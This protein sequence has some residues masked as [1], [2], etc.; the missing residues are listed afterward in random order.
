MSLVMDYKPKFCHFLF[1]IFTV[2]FITAC[3][4]ELSSEPLAII[5]T[6][7]N[8][9]YYDSVFQYTFGVSGGEGPYR[10]RY[11]QNPEG[12]EDQDSSFEENPVEMSIEVVDGAKP[13]FIL[14]GTP[15]VPDGVSFEELDSGKFKY[16]LEVSD[17]N[18]TIKREFEFTLKKNKLNFLDDLT[19][20]EG[21]VENRVVGTLNTQIAVENS[22]VC[23]QVTENALT[24]RVNEFGETVYPF[25]FQVVADV[26]TASKTEIFYRF[27][28]S[29]QESQPERAN[30]NIS[31][32]RK[33]VDYVD[34]V[35][36]I[37]LEANKARC[38]AYIEL[39][40]D[41][42]IE[43][44][45]SVTIEFYDS[46][47]GAIDLSAASSTL[48]IR[49]NEIKPEYTTANMVRN[50]GDKIVVPI[51][52]NR[53]V[54]YPISVN[55]SVD[56]DTTANNEDFLLEP[57]SGVV[58]LAPGEIQSSYVITLLD[59]ASQDAS[60]ATK[61]KS[62][63]ITTDLDEILNVEPLT[64]EINEWAS[65]SDISKEIVGKDS[66]TEKII[67]FTM[68][69][70]G[71]ITTLA[72]DIK[73][74]D[75]VVRLKSYRRDATNFDFSMEGAIELSKVG[76]DLKPVSIQ[77]SLEGEGYRLSIVL[78]VNGLYGDVFRG[79][80]DFVVMNYFRNSG[81]SFNLMSVKQYG[82]EG[83][84]EVKGSAILGST[85]Y[86]YGN[87]NGSDFEGTPTN[88]TNSGGKDGFIY[89]INLQNNQFQWARFLGTNDEDSVVA[90][91]VANRD[92]VAAISTKTTDEDV[93]IRKL[94]ANNGQDRL[95][96]TPV[97]I[98]SNNLDD[99]A[100]AIEFD[101]SA[102]SFRVL[103]DS[104]ADLDTD[105]EQTPT[106]SRDVQLL[107][108]NLDNET[109]SVIAYATEFE[110][111]AKGLSTMPSNSNLIVS[112]ETFGEFPD[113]LKR[114]SGDVDLFT[115]II[116]LDRSAG[117]K[118]NKNIQFG[119][120]KNDSIISV[121]PAS[122]TKYFVLWKE[123][124]SNPLYDTY[125]ISAFSIDGKK[126]SRDP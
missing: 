41:T 109:P 14:R 92:I 56:P 80:T 73:N 12:E 24:K 99:M 107:T 55:V 115:A 22:S 95:D 96:Y 87:T 119:T 88:E 35:R 111:I 108:F 125:R 66:A 76:L 27:K 34:A 25:A 19:V 126:L 89:S 106:L 38:I 59:N 57:Q 120:T 3:D 60:N 75:T 78:N 45:E 11:I 69:E 13:S 39:L 51:T 62:I 101:A 43:G 86:V 28:T 52:L 83:D 7:A 4:T 49:D 53:A 10:Y 105:N 68:D 17:G 63:T 79:G 94:N 61:D 118:L 85:L 65:T 117:T 123:S 21:T 2:M 29:Y 30:R 32:A 116:D 93:F 26:R 121:K 77:S 42:A 122:D 84:D 48:E 100:A 18:N 40:D 15:K 103:L 46:V 23:N 104:V 74:S 71:I 20:T 58:K 64:I 124:F 113:N 8:T 5:G 91:D 98:A 33:G 70:E 81:E 31:Y 67:D 1:C 47:G 102:S 114:G 72:S 90:I 112:G 44:F 37:T 50:R 110:D 6:P 54:D 9:L 97:T 82:S 16:E 36:S